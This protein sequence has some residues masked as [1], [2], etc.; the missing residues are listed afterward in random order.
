MDKEII[1]RQ[2]LEKRSAMRGADVDSMSSNIVDAVLSL[3][4]WELAEEVLLYWPIRNEVDVRPL[5]KNAW[6]GK[7]EAFHALLP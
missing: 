3:E 6:D 7:K 4:Q 2:L 1:R 5:L